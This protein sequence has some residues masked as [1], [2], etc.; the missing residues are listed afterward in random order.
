MI[1]HLTKHHIHPLKL[2]FYTPNKNKM[3]S[4]SFLE[5]APSLE[6]IVKFKILR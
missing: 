3:F 4:F 5:D 2:L 6:D 1:L